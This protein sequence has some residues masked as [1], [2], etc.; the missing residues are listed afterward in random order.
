VLK[1]LKGLG[2]LIT[3]QL[4]VTSYV[5]IVPTLTDFKPYIN[6]VVVD[7]ELSIARFVEETPKLVVIEAEQVD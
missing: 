5:S 3:L 2:I 1:N 7:V 4:T 6:D